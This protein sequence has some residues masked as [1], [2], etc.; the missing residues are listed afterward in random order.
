MSHDIVKRDLFKVLSVD[1]NAG[2]LSQHFPIGRLW[3][4]VRDYDSNIGKLILGLAVEYYRLGLL[5]E[6]VSD[7]IDLNK[8]TSLLE[9]WEKSVGIPDGCFSNTGSDAT[10][11]RNIKL[12][13]SNFQGVQTKEDFIR[14]AEV[15]GFTITIK[16]GIDAGGFPLNFPITN[17]STEKAAQFTVVVTT[18]ID[19]EDDFFP[20][21]FPLPFSSGGTTLLKCIFEMLVQANVNVIILNA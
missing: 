20:L 14:V 21:P 12:L 19:T 2:F 16:N 3:A 4:K 8:T 10:R 9:E 7:E 6:K 17:F 5:V 15:F 18:S 1:Q 11:R 13:F